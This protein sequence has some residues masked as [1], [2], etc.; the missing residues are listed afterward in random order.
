M[1][2]DLKNVNKTLGKFKISDINLELPPGYIMGL[3]G[4]NGAGKTSLIHIILGLYKC[5][6]GQVLI[7]GKA[8]E[9]DEVDIRNLTGT[10]LLEELFYK[11]MTLVENGNE[12]GR[13]FE[14]YD[15]DILRKYLERFNIESDRK[16]KTLSKGEKIKFQFAFALSHNARLLVLDEP[17]GNLDIEFRKEFFKVLKEFIADGTRS[18]ILSSHLT[19]D[20]DKIAD[21]IFYIENGETIFS[22]DIETLRGSYRLLTGEEYKLKLLPKEHV[23]YMEQGNYGSRALVHHKARYTYDDSLTVAVPTIEELM[24]FTTKRK[25]DTSRRSWGS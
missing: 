9:T 12:Y 15:E 10:V 7:D 2:V 16:Y 4:P 18:V 1:L 8:Y 21:Y 13:F 14:D 5:S 19:E 6:E 22:G 25:K 17:T 3:I 23:I 11:G 20:L 24:Y